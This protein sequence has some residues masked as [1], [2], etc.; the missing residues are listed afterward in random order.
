MSKRELKRLSRASS[1]YSC[2]YGARAH[3]LLSSSSR[4]NIDASIGDKDGVVE[5][6]QMMSAVFADLVEA[7]RLA[8]RVWDVTD[9]PG[10]M[11]TSPW[12][13]RANLSRLPRHSAC[14]T[15]QERR[16]PCWDGSGT[17]VGGYP[18][19][20][21]LLGQTPQQDARAAEP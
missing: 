19:V 6:V 18:P 12:F 7:L 1:L 10:R 20:W 3:C 17:T 21:W 13:K 9:R 8:T 15:P 2:H 16:K 5:L 4:D 14:R 11:M